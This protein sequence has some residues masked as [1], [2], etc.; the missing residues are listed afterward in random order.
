M[1]PDAASS[2]PDTQNGE[3]IPRHLTYQKVR[4]G[5]KQPIRGLWVRNGRYYARLSVE[6]QNTGKKGVRRIPLEGAET[7]SQAILALKKLQTKR[8]DNTLPVLK[9]T[10]KFSD[11]VKSYFS[12]FEQVKDAKRPR[13]LETERGHLNKWVEHLCDTRLDRINKAKINAFI[14]K[15]QGEGAGARTV[16]L[17]VG[18][19]RNVLNRAIDDEWLQRMP[20]EGIRPLKWTPKK[21]EL[22]SLADINKLCEAAIKAS[23][24][25]AQFSDY[26]KLM[27]FCGSRMSETLRLKWADV[28]WTQNQLTIG[29][30]GLAKNHKPRVVDF[31]PALESHLKDVFARRAP[32]SEFLFPSPQRGNKDVRAKTFRETLLLA[33]KEAG[34]PFFGFHHCRHFFISYA[35]MSGTSWMTI[36]RF[37]GHQD[38][39]ILIG[40]TYGHLTNEFARQQAQRINFVP[41]VLEQAVA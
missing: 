18:A 28:D 29:S 27:A 17:A 1:K 41:V 31:N 10:P 24:N 23:K 19:L 11:Y 34:L 16:N 33:R 40:K 9:Q 15:R 7:V 13:T 14:A 32:D 21:K 20:T 6:D 36:A 5:R 8:D 22:V 38:G 2:N 30:D 26:I 37:V 39:G 25:G 12:F 4:D 35:V 3:S